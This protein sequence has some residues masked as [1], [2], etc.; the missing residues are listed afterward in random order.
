MTGRRGS[1]PGERRCGR[2]KGTP[3][4]TPGNKP[5][6][7]KKE[8]REIFLPPEAAGHMDGREIQVQTEPGGPHDPH[9]QGIEDPLELL[10]A[11]VRDDRLAVNYRMAAAKEV[12]PYVRSKMSNQPY[13]PPDHDGRIFIEVVE[14]SETDFE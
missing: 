2:K 4:K 3:N 10:L 8:V 5:K 13:K 11:V 12:L 9:Y 1:G 6:L 14:F 7:T